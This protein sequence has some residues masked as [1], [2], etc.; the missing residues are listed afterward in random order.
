LEAKAEGEEGIINPEY[1]TDWPGLFL[2][3]SVKEG[4]KVPY[5]TGSGFQIF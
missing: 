1:W 4:I 5:N 2:V 3:E